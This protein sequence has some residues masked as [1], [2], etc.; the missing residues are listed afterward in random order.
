MPVY[1][2]APFLPKAIESILAQTHK[3]FEFIIVDDGSQDDSPEIIAQFAER[4]SR[5][6]PIFRT[7]NPAL[8][9]GAQ[10]RHD[11]IAIAKG[12][13]IAAM[14]SDD[15]ALPDRLAVQLKTIK[16]RNLDL[17]GGQAETFGTY[18]G[19]IWFPES[20]E[21]IDRELVFRVGMLHPTFMAKSDFMRRLP[22]REDIAHED[23]ELL[24]RA[25][26]V[27]RLG[28]CPET[29][30]RYRQHSAQATCVN[31]GAL[32]S[33]LL[34]FRFHHFYRLFPNAPASEFQLLNFVAGKR[35]LR[36][37]AELDIVAKYLCRLANYPDPKLRQR[38]VRRWLEICEISSF[39][40]PN[41]K[42]KRIE[43][44]ILG[45]PDN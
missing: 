5:I 35:P 14:D 28:N 12:N 31:S 18:V 25:S 6:K 22:Y 16:D 21:A 17:C 15:I 39:E 42:I 40:V 19:A 11:G 43:E 23:Y 20:A 8:K 24:V 3:E 10:A 7:R 27:G 44:Q 37:Q 38:N 1:D 2:T 26:Q 9:T 45:K 29:V 36:D 13:Y 41:S 32:L 34:H 30:L 33:D 4:D